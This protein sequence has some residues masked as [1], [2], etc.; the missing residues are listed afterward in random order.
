MHIAQQ[1]RVKL[2][3]RGYINQIDAVEVHGEGEVDEFGPKVMA[4]S[5]E[6]GECNGCIQELLES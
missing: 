4:E 2:V 5:E 6:C 1:S 3:G